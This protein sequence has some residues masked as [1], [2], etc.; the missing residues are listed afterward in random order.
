MESLEPRSPSRQLPS[1]VRFRFA[2]GVQSFARTSARVAQALHEAGEHAEQ[3]L[4][5]QRAARA[6]AQATAERLHR[7]QAITDAALTH[8]ALDDL[9]RE[10]LKRVRELLATD[11]AAVLFLDGGSLLVRAAVGEEELD[12]GMRL[13]I[14]RGFCGRVARERRV[15]GLED[16]EEDDI[17]S[18]LLREKGLKSMLG[19]PLLVEGR[20][21]GTMHLGTLARR[22]W[23][24]DDAELLE[25]V[26]DRVAWALDRSRLY[27]AERSARGDA[28]K[29]AA[30][31]AAERDRLRS[32]ITERKRAEADR[33]RLTSAL[34]ERERQLQ[35]LVGR[36]I[37][38]QEEERRRVAYE[39]HDGLAQTA[40]GAHLHLRGF[41]RRYGE[42]VPE[43]REELDRVLELAQRVVREARTVVSD[44]RPTALDDLGL[45]AALEAEVEELQKE[46]WR[47]ELR[48]DLGPTRLEPA[49]ET[50]LF[51]VAQEALRN[52]RKHADATRAFVR[53]QRTR[54]TARLEVRDWGRGFDPAAAQAGAGPGERVG[55]SGMRE[56]CA[57]LGG[58]CE[59]RSRPGAGT[60]IIAE[61]PLAGAF[62]HP[63]RGAVGAP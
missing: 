22:C 5:Q 28:E 56:R 12:Q 37:L 11:T 27:E 39:L 62:A 7:L 41:A 2:S 4:A 16:V 42:R 25:L 46:G 20:E 13:P 1:S 31:L 48:A 50:A 61:V 15:L 19:A 47:V 30:E 32:E 36:L 38:A 43:E 26:A 53:L 6:E 8:F 51:R 33:A 24:A 60:R 29:F 21:L 57:L 9:L 40:A 59:V 54:R 58:R 63:P 3:A 14:G 34:A 55:L 23:S 10:L 17:L 45:E 44:L 49:V 18:P 52:A 35:D